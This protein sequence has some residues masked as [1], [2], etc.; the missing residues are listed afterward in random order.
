MAILVVGLLAGGALGRTPGPGPVASSGSS[1]APA[2]APREGSGAV[3]VVEFSDFQCPACAAV[4]PGLQQLVDDGSITLVYRYFPL[5]Q[6]QNAT[7]AARAAAAAQLQGKFWPLHDSMFSSQQAWESLS[8]SDA[9]A[10][11][12]QLA[13]DA[14]LDVERWKA[15]MDTAAVRDA[16]QADAQAADTLRLPGTPSLFINGT[17]YSGSLTVDALRAAVAAAGS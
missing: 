17:L 2:S 6:H 10:Y 13:T 9:S 4:S 7:L 5:P 14:G 8:N 3:T 15:D 1:L 11:F 16:V 12:T